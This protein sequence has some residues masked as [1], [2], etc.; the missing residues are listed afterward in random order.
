M[1]A[2]NLLSLRQKVSTPPQKA[3]FDIFSR[4]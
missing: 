2:S 4:R 1:W 3:A